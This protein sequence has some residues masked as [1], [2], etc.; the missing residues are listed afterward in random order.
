LPD[1]SATPAQDIVLQE[2]LYD[3]LLAAELDG[4][5]RMAEV[6]RVKRP[7]DVPQENVRSLLQRQVRHLPES[8][9]DGGPGGVLVLVV[10][11]EQ[12]EADLL[13]AEKKERMLVRAARADA[14]S[15]VRTAQVKKDA[16]IAKSAANVHTAEM[17]AWVDEMREQMNSVEVCTPKQA[18]AVAGVPA[19]KP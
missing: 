1:L 4:G 13:A 3:L 8:L 10:V 7:L 6:R 9:G 19:A 16:M 17:K 2:T 14:E 5:L 15:K 18:N 11:E 12:K